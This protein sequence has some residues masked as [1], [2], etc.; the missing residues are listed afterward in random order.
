MATVNVYRTTLPRGPRLAGLV[1]RVVRAERSPAAHTRGPSSGEPATA[2]GRVASP[3][4]PRAQTTA[5]SRAGCLSD[6]IGVCRRVDSRRLPNGRRWQLASRLLNNV[7]RNHALE[8]GTVTMLL[9]AGARTPLGGYSTSGGFFIFGRAS[10]EEVRTAAQEALA[11][12]QSGREELAISPHCGTNLATAALLG[13]PPGEGDS[14]SRPLD[15]PAA[16]GHGRHSRGRPSKPSDRQLAAAALHHPRRTGRPGD[17]PGQNVVVRRTL[18][19]SH[20]HVDAV[21]SGGAGRPGYSTAYRHG[22]GTLCGFRCYAKLETALS[23]PCSSAGQSGCL[24]SSGSRVRILPGT[25]TESCFD[26]QICVCWQP[27]AFP[28]MGIADVRRVRRSRAVG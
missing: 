17:H 14:R 6:M 25:P 27:H 2:T 23:C 5:I 9:E 20:Q 18:A 3:T 22:S 1:D 12:L 10:L 8:H 24:L 16:Y 28:D 19:L 11:S 4:P 26:I 21:V 13:G 15:L 7:R